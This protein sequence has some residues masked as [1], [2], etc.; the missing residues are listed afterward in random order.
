MDAPSANADAASSDELE[1]LLD[2]LDDDLENVDPQIPRDAADADADTDADAKALAQDVS[3]DLPPDAPQDAVQRYDTM[4][5][6]ALLDFGDECFDHIVKKLEELPG[7]SP[8]C[9]KTIDEELREDILG[10]LRNTV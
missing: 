4:I 9:R 10:P 7:V 5:R 2:A 3:Q 6:R 8:K 1:R